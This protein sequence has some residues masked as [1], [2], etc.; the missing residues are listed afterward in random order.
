MRTPRRGE[1]KSVGH[2]ISRCVRYFK[3]KTLNNFGIETWIWMCRCWWMGEMTQGDNGK[4]GKECLGF[5]ITTTRHGDKH[6]PSDFHA[7]IP[8]DT[9]QYTLNKKHPHSTQGGVALTCLRLSHTSW[10]PDQ[11]GVWSM[12]WGFTSLMRWIRREGLRVWG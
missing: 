6:N 11:T 4:E 10:R 9:T 1:G 5:I 2:C 8:E 7:W 12:R 3:P